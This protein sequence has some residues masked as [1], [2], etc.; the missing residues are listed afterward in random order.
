MG[1]NIERTFLQALDDSLSPRSE[2]VLEFALEQTLTE[3]RGNE[4][5]IACD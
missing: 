2:A 3:P 4:C 5:E 1:S